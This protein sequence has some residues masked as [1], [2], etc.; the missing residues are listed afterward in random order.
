MATLSGSLQELRTEIDLILGLDSLQAAS[1]TETEMLMREIEKK[2]SDFKGAVYKSLY[3]A[4]GSTR[5]EKGKKD[6]KKNKTGRFSIFNKT[7]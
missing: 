3:R 2:F 1:N 5:S 6:E 4:Y 7:R